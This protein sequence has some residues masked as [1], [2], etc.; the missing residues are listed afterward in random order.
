MADIPVDKQLTKRKVLSHINSVFDMHGWAAPLM[1]TAKLI[2]SEICKNSYH[3][4]EKL[5][6]EVA[7]R[8]NKWRHA[9][10]S[11]HTVTVPRSIHTTNN[12]KIEL[13]GFADASKHA[14]CAAIYAVELHEGEPIS[15]NLLVAK[16]RIAPVASIPRLELIAAHTL[17]KLQSHVS[18]ALKDMRIDKF[19]YW[20][21]ST[22]VLY[23]LA[24]KGTWS[25]FVRNRTKKIKELTKGNWQ[26]VPTAE[27]PADLGTRAIT[28][29]KLGELWLKGPSYLPHLKDWPEQP[30]IKETSDA[31]TEKK[32][33][34][35]KSMMAT[36]Q[37]AHF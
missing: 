32:E 14:V 12:S 21:D 5:P 10:A 36:N 3:W 16:S 11:H 17:A 26:Y 15:Q 30:E 6:E 27:N 29:T 23:W 1:V 34:K 8:W 33:P 28:P 24:D 22:T 37:L 13:H 18:E 35:V 31:L 4:D 2:F 25:V 20:S 19:H 9:L 7:T